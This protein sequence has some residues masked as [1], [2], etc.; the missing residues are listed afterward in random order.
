MNAHISELLVA[1]V[2]LVASVLLVNPLDLWMPSVL[3]MGML[4]VF[5]AAAGGI[6]TFMMR[7]KAI[8]ER[9]DAHRAHAGRAAFFAGSTILLAGITIQTFAHTLDSWLVA[10]L[11][12]MVLAKVAAR[13][14]SEHNS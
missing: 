8:D 11:V 12:G 14:W 1:L 9:D 4:A 2:L 10:A 6:A 3:T 7:E 5:V 13:W